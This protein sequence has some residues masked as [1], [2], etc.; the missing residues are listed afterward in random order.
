MFSYAR[1]DENVEEGDEHFSKKEQIFNWLFDN[2]EFYVMTELQQVRT[3]F[4]SFRTGEEIKFR[5]DICAIRPSDSQVLNIEIDGKEHFTE[6]GKMQ[7]R[8]RDNWLHQQYG[9]KVFRVNKYEDIDWKNLNLF[10]NCKPS[11]RNKNINTEI[12][13]GQKLANLYHHDSRFNQ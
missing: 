12:T 13:L 1:H 9:I 10:I 5:M 3:P 6:I 7:D 11:P 4:K 2:T 8:T